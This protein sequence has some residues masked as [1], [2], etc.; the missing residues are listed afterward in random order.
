LRENPATKEE[1]T[2]H[3]KPRLKLASRRR[4][5]ELLFSFFLV[6][7]FDIAY[8]PSFISLLLVSSFLF[9]L[10]VMAQWVCC[11]VEVG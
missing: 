11:V 6:A 9:V 7:A 4:T 3:I 10:W 8:F 2:L 5:P 1:K